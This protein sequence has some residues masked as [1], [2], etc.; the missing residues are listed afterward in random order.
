[1]R[2]LAGGD[3]TRPPDFS[4]NLKRYT[5]ILAFDQ[6]LGFST[7]LS[8]D[9]LSKDKR[10]GLKRFRLFQM[11]VTHSFAGAGN[12]TAGTALMPNGFKPKPNF[13]IR[14]YIPLGGP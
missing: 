6:P 3:D 5:P 11:A 7:A 4:E 1:M 9:V 14:F 12:V 8:V 2:Y 13:G 10:Q